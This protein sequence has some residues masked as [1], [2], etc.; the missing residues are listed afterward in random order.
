VYLFAK[1]YY[2]FHIFAEPTF[3]SGFVPWQLVLGVRE[4]QQQ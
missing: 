1:G 4:W 2:Y 3:L